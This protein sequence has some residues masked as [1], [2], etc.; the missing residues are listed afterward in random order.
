[1]ETCNVGQL[2]YPVSLSQ[3]KQKVQLLAKFGRIRWRHMGCFDSTL[4]RNKSILSVSGLRRAHFDT[5]YVFS[6]PM[7]WEKSLRFK[8]IWNPY[9]GMHILAS[10]LEYYYHNRI[11][12][13]A[14]EYFLMCSSPKI[15][16][17]NY[18]SSQKSNN[19]TGISLNLL[20]LTATPTCST[21]LARK[22]G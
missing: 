1:M 11:T 2:F 21:Y 6:C 10:T 18:V 17:S 3:G 9:L 20:S 22:Q 7:K 13:S 4:G 5:P 12:V 14:G 16:T 15:W 19:I 8:K